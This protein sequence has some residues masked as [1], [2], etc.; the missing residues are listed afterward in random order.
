MVRTPSASVDHRHSS[1]RSADGLV[2][3]TLL[4]CLA[5]AALMSCHARRVPSAPAAEHGASTP[6]GECGG[7]PDAGPSLEAPQDRAA[8]E[9]ALGRAHSCLLRQ[10]RAVW[11]WGDNRRAQ[12]GDGSRERRLRPVRAGVTAPMTHVS[13]GDDHVCV[14]TRA[15]AGGVPICWG[16]NQGRQLAGPEQDVVAK[17][18][19]LSWMEPDSV[20]RY[21]P[22]AGGRTQCFEDHEEYESSAS[23]SGELAAF[24]FYER[25]AGSPCRPGVPCPLW[26]RSV[27]MRGSSLCFLGSGFA[28]ISTVHCSPD[29]EMTMPD[30]LVTP[31]PS[32]I[33]VGRGFA[34]ARLENEEIV[35]W[36][37]DPTTGA[38]RPPAARAP[39]IA[40][41]VPGVHLAT[42]L[43]AGE[44]FACALVRD[45]SAL[46]GPEARH[47]VCWG[48]L[49]TKRS[50]P[51]E[52]GY[53]EPFT[54]IACGARHVCMLGDGGVQ[55]LGDN[56]SGQLGD[57]TTKTRW[58][59]SYTTVP[60]PE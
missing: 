25:Y 16:D 36:G 52:M 17:P 11:C 21:M 18:S 51:E 4:S 37:D 13:S 33:A 41:P 45:R 31:E 1:W 7:P 30:A 34:C 35:C 28:G 32:G 57:G 58:E 55:C 12:L 48:L 40:R 6:P 49:G 50:A 20:G 26:I 29:L 22:A 56:E 42:A 54:Q 14:T 39:A 27:S 43:C 23:C 59:P 15:A 53:T 60:I 3:R 47:V 24:P 19:P 2:M 8:S 46:G 44:Q 38:R 9:L 5:A 10:G